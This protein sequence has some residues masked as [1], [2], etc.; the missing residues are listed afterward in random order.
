MNLFWLHCLQKWQP[1]IWVSIFMYTNTLYGVTQTSRESLED[2][3]R[4]AGG[5]VLKSD[6]RRSQSLGE[7]VVVVVEWNEGS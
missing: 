2:R 5:V 7:N 4:G 1:I 6:G 3:T